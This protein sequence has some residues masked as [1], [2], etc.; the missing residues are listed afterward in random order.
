MPPHARSRPLAA[1]VVVTL[2]VAAL[3]V[4]CQRSPVPPVAS[5]PPAPAWPALIDE[6]LAAFFAAH[7]SFASQQ[8]RHE[9]DGQLPDWSAAGIRAE[10]ARLKAFRDRVTAFP[11][12]QL[13]DAQRFER[14]YL[15]TRIDREI[16]WRDIAE[17]PFTN[18]EFYLGMSDGG[19]SLDPSNYVVRPYGTPELRLRAFIKYTRSVLQAVPEIRKNLRTPMPASY[20]KLGVDGFGGLAEFYRHDV[21]QAF[22]GVGDAAL[23]AELNSAI[24]P[25]AKALDGLA[26]WLNSEKPRA[27]RS[28]ALGPE[29]FAAMLRMTERVELPLADLDA[30]GRADLDRNIAALNEACG[31]F[32]PRASLAQ[33]V[34]RV[35]A[36][37]PEGGPVAAARTL[38]PGLRQFILDKDIASIPGPEQA[39]VEESPP[40]NRQNFAY[41]DTPGPYEKSLP[42]VYYIAPPDPSWSKAEQAAYVPGRAMLLFTSAHEVWPGHFLQFMWANRARSRLASLFVGYAYAEGWA[43]YGEEL[44]WEKGLGGDPETHIG[45][46]SEA[47]LRDVR[48]VS[49]IGLHTKGMTISESEKLFRDSAFQDPGTARQQAARGTYDPGYLNYT[50]GKLMIR[51]L[52]TDYCASRGAEACWKSFHDRFLSYGGPPIPLVRRAMLPGDNG[53]VL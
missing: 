38:L 27:S 21:P 10:V 45:Q 23:Q 9:Y 8:G 53:P 12:A 17:A 50:L 4:G 39:K 30:A 13:D 33:C 36:H 2:F 25:A 47:L 3:V 32:A 34:A 51:K 26:A 37:K 7:P 44:M 14:E 28:D 18:P 19:D 41:I 52:R 5:A 42:S 49:A 6:Y 16:F 20:I 22:A 48:F 31:R 1:A 35:R 43:H 11:D 24:E 46:L 15:L 40:Y 29:R